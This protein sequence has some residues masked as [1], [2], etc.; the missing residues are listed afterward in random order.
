MNKDYRKQ[1]HC[2]ACNRYVQ[3]STRYPNY[4]C[5]KCVSKAVDKK[6]EAIA[7]FNVTSDGQGCQ[8]KLLA[9]NKSTSSKSCFIKGI[10]FKAEEAYLGGIVLLPKIKRSRTSTSK[11]IKII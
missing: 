8:G 5:A 11:N 2:P 10:D 4:A 9:T 3:Y 7:F 6:G 1:Q